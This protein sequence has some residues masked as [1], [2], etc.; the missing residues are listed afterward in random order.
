M[1]KSIP[2]RIHY[3]AA[4]VALDS[5]IDKGVYRC[6]YPEQIANDIKELF[7]IDVKVGSGVLLN[8]DYFDGN[9]HVDTTV[10]I[11]GTLH[12]VTS[13][14]VYC[15]RSLNSRSWDTTEQRNIC[16]KCFD[17]NEQHEIKELFGVE[18]KVG[19]GVLLKPNFDFEI[20]FVKKQIEQLKDVISNGNFV[21]YSEAL[22]NRKER[23]ILA[24][25]TLKQLENSNE[26]GQLK[27]F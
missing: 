26:V 11:N 21:G 27:L 22:A 17:V 10:V 12:K 15:N 3:N 24:E 1:E 5:V 25:K 14:Y 7:G 23:L 9:L 19:S 2:E 16:E 8:R 20:E 6:A 4:K 18:V 13:K